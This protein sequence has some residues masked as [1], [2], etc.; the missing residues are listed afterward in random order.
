MAREAFVAAAR[1]V[2]RY[3]LTWTRLSV[4]QP[5]RQALLGREVPGVLADAA[6]TALFALG[7]GPIP[8]DILATIVR[9]DPEQSADALR[10]LLLADASV[11]PC[12]RRRRPTTGTTGRSWRGAHSARL[13]W[14]PSDNSPRR[15]ACGASCCRASAAR[16]RFYVE[17]WALDALPGRDPGGMRTRPRP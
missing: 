8:A 17:Q 14:T 15:P 12:S 7:P 1:R 5:R 3:A 2:G 9:G 13:S 6:G 16:P 11:R 10:T 4:G